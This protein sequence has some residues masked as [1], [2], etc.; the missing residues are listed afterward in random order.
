MG[1]YILYCSVCFLYVEMLFSLQEC[2]LHI[3][4]HIHNSLV[5]AAFTR[6][7]TCWHEDFSKDTCI[8]EEITTTLQDICDSV[9]R[10][11]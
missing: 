9:N 2:Q 6:L 5:K 4:A 1:E 7:T 3:S 11:S 8:A 10:D